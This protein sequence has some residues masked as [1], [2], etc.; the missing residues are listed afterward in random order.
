MPRKTLLSVISIFIV[1]LLTA[2]VSTPDGYSNY[3]TDNMFNKGYF[4]KYYYELPLVGDGQV[5]LFAQTKSTEERPFFQ[6]TLTILEIDGEKLLSKPFFSGKDIWPYIKEGDRKI[7]CSKDFSE[8]LCEAILKRQE[9]MDE[10]LNS[11]EEFDNG[12]HNIRGQQSVVFRPGT[13]KVKLLLFGYS[14]MGRGDMGVYDV[15]AID[16]SKGRYY[17]HFEVE[18][19]TVGSRNVRIWIV[20]EDTGEVVWEIEDVT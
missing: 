17:A 5:D 9:L 14:S 6:K 18:G 12:R 4:N 10:M 15:D 8:S 2:C 7:F 19:N 20:E 11:R 3:P 1:S 16:F 13:R